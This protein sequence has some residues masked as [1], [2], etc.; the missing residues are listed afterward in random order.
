MCGGS[1]TRLSLP[2]VPRRPWA[3]LDARSAAG[4]G[5]LQALG[6]HLGELP[7][8][9][10]AHVLPPLR[11]VGVVGIQ[12]LGKLQRHD[13]KLIWKEAEKGD[14]SVLNSLAQTAPGWGSGA[15]TCPGWSQEALDSDPRAQQPHHLLKQAESSPDFVFGNQ[16]LPW[17][18]AVVVCPRQD[19]CHWL[20]SYNSSDKDASD[21]DKD[22]LTQEGGLACAQPAL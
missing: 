5:R 2:W 20:P 19:P 17:M 14:C 3:S 10:Q 1:A 16:L 22:A 8:D 7:G 9:H 15:A 4:L 13:L 11:R 6:G 18:P 21:D 12:L